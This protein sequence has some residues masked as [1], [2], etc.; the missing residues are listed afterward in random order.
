MEFQRYLAKKEYLRTM[1]NKSS[2]SK[3]IS[4]TQRANTKKNFSRAM[5]QINS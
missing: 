3:K 1:K 2:K 4:E 5:N